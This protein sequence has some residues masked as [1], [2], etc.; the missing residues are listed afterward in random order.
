MWLLN[1]CHIILRTCSELNAKTFS[2]KNHAVF[3]SFFSCDE[4]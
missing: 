1:F 4:P 3:S 2:L